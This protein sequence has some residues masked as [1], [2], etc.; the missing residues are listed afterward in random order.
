MPETSLNV[1]NTVFV[2]LQRAAGLDNAEC[3]RFLGIAEG[4]VRDR[5]R[6]AFKPRRSELFSL[7][8]YGTAS[9]KMAEKIISDHCDHDFNSDW[10]CRVCR[11][12]LKEHVEHITNSLS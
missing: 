10:V 2:R 7:A 8:I 5:R 4:A 1:E 12:D 3:G 6:G 9:E 11:M